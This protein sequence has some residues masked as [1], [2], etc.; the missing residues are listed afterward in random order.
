MGGGQLAMMSVAAL[1]IA[2][3]GW[4]FSE[5]SKSAGRRC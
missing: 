1:L 5:A 2:R 4:W 3:L